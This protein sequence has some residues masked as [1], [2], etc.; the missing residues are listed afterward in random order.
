MDYLYDRALTDFNYPIPGVVIVDIDGTLADNTGVRNPFDE[1]R[2]L[3]DKE[4]PIVTRW[5][6][7]LNWYYAIYI[8]TGRHN[9]CGQDTMHWLKEHNISYDRLYMRKAGDNRSDTVVKYE[10]LNEILDSGVGLKDI[11]FV[12]D[13]RPKVI[14]MWKQAGLTVYPARGAVEEF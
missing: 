8:V 4:Y 5:V 6:R 3:F 14:R 1:S 13:D 12:I 9:T 11:L 10:I 7:N 2:V